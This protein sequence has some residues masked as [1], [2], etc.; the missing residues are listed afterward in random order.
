MASGVR[1]AIVKVGLEDC[2][3]R[4]AT[5]RLTRQ[6][7]CKTL[8]FKELLYGIHGGSATS[9]RTVRDETSQTDV[10]VRENETE[11]T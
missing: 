10:L 4:L 9:S 1:H 2:R 11:Q 7:D 6:V 8:W 5:R 3:I